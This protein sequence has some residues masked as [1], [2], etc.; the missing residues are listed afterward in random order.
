MSQSKIAFVITATK[1]YFVLGLRLINKIN[2]HYCGDSS[3][4]IHFFSDQDPFPY[5]KHKNVTHVN[6]SHYEFEK[7]VMKK[8]TNPIN[9]N[10]KDYD[11][12]FILDADTNISKDFNDSDFIGDLVAL[13][14]FLDKTKMS[15]VKHYERNPLSSA[16]IP[17]NTELAQVYYWSCFLGGTSKNIINIINKIIKME[18]HDLAINL[19]PVWHDESYWNKI[20]HHRPPTLLLD[21]FS[22]FLGLSDKGNL[23]DGITAGAW[24]KLFDNVNVEKIKDDV[25]KLK[26]K[27]WDIAENQIIEIKQ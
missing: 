13:K 14:H 12:I 27:D 20:L 19:I 6:V 21:P 7:I 2:K 9:I 22:T 15:E 26:D 16:Y 25:K 18:E 4:D 17:Y 8:I 5:I 3:I 23:K 24:E 10:H 1:N 11:Y